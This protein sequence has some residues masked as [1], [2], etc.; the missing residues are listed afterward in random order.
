[1]AVV[2]LMGDTKVKVADLLEVTGSAEEGAWLSVEVDQE[3]EPEERSSSSS[4]ARLAFE[5]DLP[6]TR[7]LALVLLDW[8]AVA[9]ALQKER[10]A[11]A[12]PGL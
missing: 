11:A 12:P 8:V 2:L 3:L 9:E 6:Q 10:R 5:L 7:A 1:M 4:R